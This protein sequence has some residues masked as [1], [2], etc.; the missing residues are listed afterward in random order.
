MIMRGVRGLS[1]QQLV[2]T[3]RHWIANFYTANS[4]HHPNEEL[5][6]LKNT[7]KLLGKFFLICFW[8]VSNVI[9][10]LDARSLIIK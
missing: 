4:L 6:K 10:F 8:S 7:S 3:N 5:D 2:H 9:S 1:F